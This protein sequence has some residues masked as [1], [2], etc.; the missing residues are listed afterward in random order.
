MAGSRQNF[1]QTESYFVHFGALGDPRDLCYRD[2][3][4][5]YHP[6][7]RRL[8]ARACSRLEYPASGSPELALETQK[9]ITKTEVGLDQKWGLD[10]G[11]W[12]VVKHLYPLADVPVI[13]MSLDYY[14]VPQFHYDLAKEL[15]SLRRKGVLIVGSGNLVHNLH[16]V[17]WDKMN[18]PGFAFDW[19]TEANEKNEKVHPKRGIIRN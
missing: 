15:A 11:C 5:G 14:Q 6:R 1:A 2:G 12:S 10:H 4:N 9:I 7:F 8:S 19:A 16:R 3:K 13:Q 18:E 17:A